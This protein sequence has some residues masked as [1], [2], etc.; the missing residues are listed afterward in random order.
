MLGLPGDQILR[1]SAKTG[2]GVAELLD[3]VVRRIPA[4]KGDPGDPTPG[5]D[6]RL[7]LRPVPGR[8]RA[9]SGSS[10]GRCARA[11]GCASCR[12][13]P[14]HEVEEVGIRTPA[15][16]RG[17]RARPGRGRLP[18]RRHQGRRRGARRRDGHRGLA[19][20]D[21]AAR[22]LPEPEADG[23]L[24]PLPDRRRRVPRPARRAREAPAERRERHLRARD[25]RRARLRLSLRVPRPVAHGDRPR[26]PR[27]RVRPLA[28][29]DGALG[30][31]R[32]AP[33]QR[34][35]RCRSTIRRRCP[36]RRTSTTSTSRC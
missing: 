33:H 21:Q 16:V 27:A 18:H 13:G 19:P 6:V 5:A 9:R 3:E 32:R 36:S 11:P 29:R 1:I 20:G 34:R 24:R 4:P 14:T 22:G 17:R 2:E 7:L 10:T 30:R 15:P 31:V 25:D 12:P 28:H 35:G 8:R 26:A 23:V